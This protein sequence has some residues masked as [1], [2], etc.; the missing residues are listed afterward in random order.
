MSPR[1][2]TICI[3]SN[4]HALGVNV[5]VTV[6]GEVWAVHPVYPGHV[7]PSGMAKSDWV[8]THVP[9]GRRA[10]CCRTRG[11][12]IAVAQTLARQYSCWGIRAKWDEP[13]RRIPRALRQLMSGL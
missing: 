4:A 9:S 3:A 6:F 5:L 1:K 2:T 13:P 8:V 7:S 11:D 10:R 12:A